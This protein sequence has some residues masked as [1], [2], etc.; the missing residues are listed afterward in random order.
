VSVRRLTEP[1]TN[2]RPAEYPEFLAYRDAIRHSYWLHTEY[3]LTDDVHDFR[4]RATPVERS[5]IRNTLLAI[6]Q[7]EVAVKTFWG[8]L[9]H[10]YPKPEVG[11][12]GF[13]FAESEVRHQDAYAHLLEVLG[14]N[15]EFERLEEFPALRARVRVL[16]EHLKRPR[17]YDPEADGREHAL[18]VLLFAAFVEHASLFAQFLIM[19]AFD[20]ERN[21]FKGV[22]NIVEATSKEEQIHAMFGYKLVEVLR[23]ENPHWF[24]AAFEARVLAACRD[25][26][27][28]EAAILDWIFE[29][30][31]LDFLLEPHGGLE[32]G[33]VGLE[34]GSHADRFQCGVE[35]VLQER[36]DDVLREQVD[37]AVLE[38]PVE[39]VALGRHGLR[40]GYAHALL[41]RRVEPVRV[42]G[43]EGADEL[44]TELAVDL[45]LL[46]GGLHDVGDALEQ[47]PLA[48]ECLHDE[49]LPEQA[50]VLDERT[51]QHDLEG[52]LAAVSVGVARRGRAKMILEDLHPG[53]QRGDLGDALELRVQ[54]QHL[55]QERVR[56]LVPDLR[57]GE[58]V[59]DRA[60]LRLGVELEQVAPERLD[61]HLD[62]GDGE[63]GVADGGALGRAHARAVVVHVLA[64]VE[65]GVQPVRVP[66]RV[67]VRQERRVLDRPQA[68]AFV[69]E[70]QASQA[71]QVS[72]SRLNSCA[73]LR[74]CW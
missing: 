12:V 35:A 69:G 24:D 27:A 1:R 6:A 11:A 62:L 17:S 66:D 54:A 61:G 67:A 57:L 4:T 13:T 52:V 41:E 38:D 44:V 43:L 68:D 5:A 21:R 73:A 16:E 64:E 50:D 63:H 40:A 49:E 3:N 26:R 7:V 51:E 56:V 45:L 29:A 20:R 37:L 10:R 58:G 15:A 65:L 19:K 34:Q 2:L 28:A 22:A 46:A 70:H 23:H 60:D 53:L 31:E 18:G 59:P 71:V 72:S 14:L 36:L 32:R 74:L 9:M 48:V 33:S 30:G 55:E 42:L 39:D 25:A 47:V 8:D